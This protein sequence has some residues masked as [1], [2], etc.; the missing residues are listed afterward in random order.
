MIFMHNSTITPLYYTLKL[1]VKYV[2]KIV[3]DIA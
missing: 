2:L 3:A 1:W